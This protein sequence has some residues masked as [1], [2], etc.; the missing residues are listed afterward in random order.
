[1]YSYSQSNFVFNVICHPYFCGQN[2]HSAQ[3][4]K[5]AL[6][7]LKVGN[8]VFCSGGWQPLIILS[9]STLEIEKFLIWFLVVLAGA[10]QRMDPLTNLQVAVKNSVDI[11]YF[12]CTVPYHVFFVEDGQ[13]GN[14]LLYWSILSFIW[15]QRG[16]V[17]SALDS[18]S[19]FELRSD[20]YMDLIHCS[21]EFKSTTTFVL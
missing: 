4:L 2:N 12:S 7:L 19:R 15:R 9:R 8:F 21:P 1:M 5:I 3:S 11:F 14:H 6:S 18:Q 13:M 17:A 20:R 10:V 16:R